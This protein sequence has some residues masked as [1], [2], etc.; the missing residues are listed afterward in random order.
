MS[1]AINR[2]SWLLIWFAVLT[3]GATLLVVAAAWFIAHLTLSIPAVWLLVAAGAGYLLVQGD[4]P[5]P[6][7]SAGPAVSPAPEHEIDLEDLELLHRMWQR[8]DISEATYRQA[9][10]RATRRITPPP[11][12][13]PPP[14]RRR[15][16]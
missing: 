7:A 10:A 13:P 1:R 8:G 6:V 12:P 9:V 14:P 5:R 11:P 3:G 4:G 15:W 16:W 2:L